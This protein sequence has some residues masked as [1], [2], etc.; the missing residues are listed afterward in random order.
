MEGERDKE[1]QGDASSA[2]LALAWL[3]DDDQPRLMCTEELVVVWA[4]AA[5]RDALASGGDLELKDGQIALH[6]RAHQA[7][8][9]A[10]V[11][12]CD[13]QIATLVLSARDGDGHFLLRARRI[14]ADGVEGGRV[15]LTFLRSGASFQPR[16]ADLERAFQLTPAEHRVL[17]KMAEGMNA[18]AIAEAKDLSI[19][20]VRSHIR[21]LYNKMSVTS[22][23]EIFA[24]I[25]PFRL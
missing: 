23:E 20:T 11:K 12:N 22:R 1:T 6:E 7:E 10:L 8:L 16:Y 14:E 19:E 24:R 4:N 18:E 15:C 9:G 25:R 2:R 5:A 21:S 3:E 17:L 13:T